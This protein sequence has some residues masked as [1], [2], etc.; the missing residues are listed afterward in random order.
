M[1][2]HRLAVALRAILGHGPYP[3]LPSLLPSLT[4]LQHVVRSHLG[5]LD[6]N[7]SICDS[8]LVVQGLQPPVLCGSYGRTRL[9]FL[10][11]CTAR[12]RHEQCAIHRNQLHH[13]RN[14]LAGNLGILNFS[15]QMIGF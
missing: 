10:L 15:S 7:S 1:A 12:L 4:L 3:L 5:L 6:G 9:Q 8:P 13:V 11:V 2:V 14:A